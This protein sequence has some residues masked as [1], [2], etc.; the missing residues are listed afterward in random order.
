MY[1]RY[2]NDEV[3]R[4]R[5]KQRSR[6]RYARMGPEERKRARGDVSWRQRLR[7]YGI[8]PEEYAARL[9]AQGR[10]CAICRT[11]D[12]GRRSAQFGPRDQTWC[13]DHDHVRRVIRGLLCHGCNV[14]LGLVRDREEV[15]LAMVDYLRKSALIPAPRKFPEIQEK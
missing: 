12:P 8:T 13:I 5:T 4:E 2:A 14:A 10:R 6:D 11:D 3:Y 15:L 7:R 9:E 1:N